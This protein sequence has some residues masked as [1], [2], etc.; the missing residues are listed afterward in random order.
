MSLLNVLP[1]SG[2][3][4]PRQQDPPSVADDDVLWLPSVV[5]SQL[6]DAVETSILEWP[7][8]DSHTDSSAATSHVLELSCELTVPAVAPSSSSVCATRTVTTDEY[9][10]VGDEMNGLESAMSLRSNSDGRT[11]VPCTLELIRQG[12]KLRKTETLDRS[13]PRLH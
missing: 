13:A 7:L 11:E 12:V 1:S 2:S 8:G 9:V 6:A 4:Q 3:D 10:I 5:Q